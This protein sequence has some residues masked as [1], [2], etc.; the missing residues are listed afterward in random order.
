MHETAIRDPH[1]PTPSTGRELSAPSSR[2][3]RFSDPDEYTGAVRWSKADLVVTKPGHFSV[4]ADVDRSPTDLGSSLH[5]SASAG[6]RSYHAPNRALI[7]LNTERGA[8]L[9]AGAA[10]FPPGSI[11]RLRE[12]G[13]SFRGQRVQPGGARCRC[14]SR[15]SRPL[16][17]AFGGSDFMPPRDV[18]VVTPNAC[19]MARLQKD[20]RGCG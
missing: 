12:G 16:A 2:V 18:L 19:A 13:S 3:R 9:F 1:E 5:R 10:E 7:F 15:I 4:E 8:S 11:L 17:S 14:H 20:P 6:L